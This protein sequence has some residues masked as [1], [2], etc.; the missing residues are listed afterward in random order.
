MSYDG[1]YI[2]TCMFIINGMISFCWLI[3]YRGFN[4]Q[5]IGI[6]LIHDG[7]KTKKTEKHALLAPKSYR[8]SC[9]WYIIYADICFSCCESPEQWFSVRWEVKIRTI[10]R[11]SHWL[12]YPCGD[13]TR[14]GD[15]DRRRWSS[16]C[17]FCM[18]C[19]PIGSMYAIYGNIYHQYTP[20]VSIHTIHGSYG[21]LG[22]SY[23][24]V[25]IQLSRLRAQHLRCRMR[26]CKTA[27]RGIGKNLFF[28]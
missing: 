9:Y 2:Y 8:F 1:V 17:F 28:W 11:S 13:S 21:I 12:Q 4:Q 14:F 7:S 25:I 20:N 5:T 19:L 15:F 22:T 3:I 18:N 26:S 16:N 24:P 10:F 6:S 23:H 27:S